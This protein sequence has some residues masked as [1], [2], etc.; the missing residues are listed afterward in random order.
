L[1]LVDIDGRISISLKAWRL[2]GQEAWKPGSWEA[3]KLESWDVRK[4][5]ARAIP[6]IIFYFLVKTP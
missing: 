2:G 4:P 5:T 3:W 6:L 1:P